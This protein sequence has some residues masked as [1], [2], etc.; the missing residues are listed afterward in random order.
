MKPHLAAPHPIDELAA[1]VCGHS[2]R[3]TQEERDRVLYFNPG[4]AGPRQFQLPIT[5]G[6]FRIERG[7]IAA[8]LISLALKEFYCFRKVTDS[9]DELTP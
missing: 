2:Y 4:S 1:V 7:L 5:V 3:P 8:E 6:R 9:T